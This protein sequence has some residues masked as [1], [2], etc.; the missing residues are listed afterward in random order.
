MALSPALRGMVSA[1]KHKYKNSNGKTVKPKDGR[2]VYR[3]I[4]PTPEQASWV[5]PT[6]QFWA[7]LGVHWIKADANGKPICVLGDSEVVYQKPSVVNTAIV[8]AIESA[9]DED[10]KKLYESWRSRK[11]VIVNALDRKDND[12]PII[13]ELTGTTWG[14]YLELLEIHADEGIDITDPNDG[15]DI[16][17]TR[18]GKGLQTEYSV[19]AAPGKTKPVT[20]EQLQKAEDLPAFIEANYFRGEEQKALN[21]IAQITGIAVP[22]IGN[23]SGVSTP[24]AALMSPAATVSDAFDAD[25]QEAAERRKQELIAAQQ[26]AAAELAAMEHKPAPSESSTGLSQSDE[27]LL[28][29]ELDGLTEV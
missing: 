1:A 11:T 5:P 17:I 23:S 24:T 3:I 9:V 20:K 13:L 6:G 2:N 12:T 14:N 29:A 10:S 4:A 18:T 25:A 22:A 16:I 21:A 7:D 27:D 28:L 19:T 15:I 26:E 8:M